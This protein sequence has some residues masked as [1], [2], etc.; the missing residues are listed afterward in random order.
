M[1]P[2]AIGHATGHGCRRRA[3]SEAHTAGEGREPSTGVRGGAAPSQQK[4]VPR[5]E[6]LRTWPPVVPLS[7]RATRTVSH[8]WSFGTGA[9]APR[10]CMSPPT[11]GH[12]TGH[13]CDR[14]ATREPLTVG[15]GHELSTEVLGDVVPSLQKTISRA[16]D[17]RLGDSDAR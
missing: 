1:S 5:A 15:E 14:R 9:N 3:T 10:P 11:I 16:E 8:R 2:P 17:P 4:T 12:A 6:A 13:G 7:V